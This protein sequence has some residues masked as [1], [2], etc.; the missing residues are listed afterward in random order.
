MSNR[1]RIATR[2]SKLALWQANF[3][4]DRLL[5]AHDDLEVELVGMT[6]QG[7]RWL[8][9]PL[10]EVGGK[11]L[12]VKEL[13]AA[14][15]EDKADIAVHSM[16]DVPAVLPEGFDLP[17]IAFRDAVEDVLIS[18]VGSLQELPRG[19]RVGSS[20]LRRQAQLLAVRPDLDVQPIR[21]NVDTRLQKLHDG[22]YDAI[23]LARAGL[24]R[25]ELSVDGVHVLP[26]NISL[27]A[28]GQAA[29]GVECH[30]DSPVRQYLLALADEDV[31]RCVRS[32]RAVSAGFGAD[33]SLPI[34]AYATLDQDEIVLD[35]LIADASGERILKASSRGL[36][37]EDVGNEV[38]EQ[39]YQAGAQSV[40]DSLA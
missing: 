23:V 7:D 16:K 24:N 12:F 31:A 13:E 15:L 1:I 28:P 21:G 27:P 19:A 20:S 18:P 30:V 26:I 5:E 39:L 32:E 29:L 10:S 3:I 4:R 25:L 14:M 6:T 36:N 37:P 2:Q 11:G 35:A 33:C 22:N 34:A 9:S 17:V 38:V 8:S 40:L